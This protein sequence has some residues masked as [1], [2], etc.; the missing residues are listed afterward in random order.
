MSWSEVAGAWNQSPDFKALYKA[1][2]KGVESRNKRKYRSL[3]N[4]MDRNPK[5]RMNRSFN[6]KFKK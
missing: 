3:L 1:W 4:S 5:R 6:R 2:R